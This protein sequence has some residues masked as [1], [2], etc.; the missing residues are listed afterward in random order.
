MHRSLMNFLNDNM[1]IH[2]AKRL[3]I[4]TISN[5]L[6]LN[7]NLLEISLKFVPLANVCLTLKT[8]VQLL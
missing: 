7:Y 6:N 4:S 2:L 1:Q 5:I 3:N 8:Q